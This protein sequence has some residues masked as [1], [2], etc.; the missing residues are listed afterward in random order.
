MEIKKAKQYAIIAMVMI[1]LIKLTLVAVLKLKLYFIDMDDKKAMSIFVLTLYFLLGLPA[2]WS[3]NKAFKIISSL[4]NSKT[5]HVNFLNSA[6]IAA[7]VPLPVFVLFVTDDGIGHP[8][9]LHSLFSILFIPVWLMCLIAFIIFF[10]KSFL[11]LSKLTDI[12]LFKA[13]LV[14]FMVGEIIFGFYPANLI[15]TTIYSFVY[16]LAWSKVKHVKEI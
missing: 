7:C 3:V 11:E 14:L 12:W 15:S 16:I 9:S 5:L 2:L 1:I 10:V 6:L 13:F 8:L 4:A